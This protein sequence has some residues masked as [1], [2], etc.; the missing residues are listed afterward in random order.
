MDAEAVRLARQVS[1]GAVEWLGR[2]RGAFALCR[3][4]PDYEIDANQL[5]AL[6]ELALAAGTVH[7]E[8]V[9]GHRCAATA[10]SLLEY[11]WRQ[12]DEGELLYRLQVYT[13]AA[14][15]PMEIYGLF[16]AVDLRHQRMDDLSAHLMGLRAARS[17]EHL[18]NRR[19]AVAASARRIGVPIQ[20]DIK[21]LTDQT[22][23]GGTPEPWMMDTNNAYG[24]THTV[25][26]LTDYGND[27]DGL[28]EP[29]QDYLHLWL[30]VWVEVFAETRFWDLLLEFL[31]V[32][33]CL[34]RPLF[35]PEVWRQVALAQQNDGM[36]PNGLTVPPAEA[37]LAWVNHHHPT[38]VAAVAGTLTVSR[39][40]TLTTAAATAGAGSA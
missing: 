19:L 35:F 10:E 38:I 1:E 13:P 29:L 25:F 12:F 23:L 39:A 26:H 20:D 17:T 21:A 4:V 37:H 32:G 14:T 11:A 5:K 6:S 18:P 2:M 7:R 30:P 28:A 9:A 16:A 22:W 8:A 24:V 34:K 31:I 15:H 40:L 3:D 36:M 27:P 33:T